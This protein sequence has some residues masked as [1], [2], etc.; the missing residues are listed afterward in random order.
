[1]TCC[2]LAM[3]GKNTLRLAAVVA[4]SARDP[5][6]TGESGELEPQSGGVL[7]RSSGS[8]RLKIEK[9]RCSVQ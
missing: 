3:V 9:V 6:Q 8:Q 5:S 1:M 7:I 4:E 2:S